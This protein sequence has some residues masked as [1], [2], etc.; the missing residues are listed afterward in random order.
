MQHSITNTHRDDL[1]A[2]AEA[3]NIFEVDK[4]GNNIQ[5]L[6]ECDWQT[7]GEHRS[8]IIQ[9]RLIHLLLLPVVHPLCINSILKKRYKIKLNY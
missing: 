5:I 7:Y 4:A 6:H 8:P 3:R 1:V 2:G 9:P